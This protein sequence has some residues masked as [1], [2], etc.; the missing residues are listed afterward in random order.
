MPKE[1]SKLCIR[2]VRTSLLNQEHQVQVA[3]EKEKSA[4]FQTKNRTP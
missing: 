4:N 1:G 3:I 2:A